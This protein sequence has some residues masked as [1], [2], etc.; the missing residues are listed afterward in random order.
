MKE[1]AKDVFAYLLEHNAK[2]RKFY[3]IEY[4]LFLKDKETLCVRF[5]SISMTF[6][7]D[8]L[9]YAKEK[10]LFFYLAPE[11]EDSISLV[12]KPSKFAKMT[13]EELSEALQK[14]K[15]EVNWDKLL[16]KG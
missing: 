7:K 10:E 14:E 3:P 11:Y 12:I 8:F 1:I 5:S 15:E 16:D 9:A 4:C 6:L 2:R 13:E